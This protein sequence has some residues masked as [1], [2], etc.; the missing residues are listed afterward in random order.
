[1]TPTERLSSLDASF[2]YLERPAM[3]MHV[4][5]VSVLDPRDDGPL[6]FD[7]VR[8]VLQAREEE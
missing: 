6:L 2:L 1:M 5:G 8:R 3:H 4:A 7:D